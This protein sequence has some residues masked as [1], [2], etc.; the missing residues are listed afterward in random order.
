MRPISGIAPPHAVEVTTGQANRVWHIPGRHPYVLKHYSDPARAANEAAALTLLA[1]HKVDAPRLLGVDLL[2]AMPWTAQT[3]VDAGPIPAERF[4]EELAVTLIP[5]HR[6]PGGCFGRL[7]GTPPQQTWSGYLHHRLE[8][9]ERMAPDLATMAAALHR[10]VELADLAVEPR[11]LHHDLQP[12]H[13]LKSLHNKSSA[14]LVD[15]ELA[16]FGDPVSDLARLAVRLNLDDPEIMLPLAHI[17]DS[18]TARRLHL[19]WRIHLLADAA[20]ATDPAIIS[21]SRHILTAVMR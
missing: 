16:V 4:L 3:A 21:R 11:L 12:C 9:Y 20:L 8:A 17:P 1:A 7:A 13:L 6:V 10:D 18:A 19:Y 2:G 15:W 5:V 14:V